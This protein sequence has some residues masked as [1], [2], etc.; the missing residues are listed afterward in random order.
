[1]N[2]LV[3]DGHES[4]E[5]PKKP[6]CIGHDWSGGSR[7]GRKTFNHGKRGK[8]RKRKSYSVPKNQTPDAGPLSKFIERWAAGSWRL[9]Q[10]V[11]FG[12]YPNAQVERR[13]L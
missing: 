12:S 11:N 13:I 7:F 5:I 3:S 9:G 8:T 6:E 2:I 1:M 4:F 10:Q